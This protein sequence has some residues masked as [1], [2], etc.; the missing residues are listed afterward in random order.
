MSERYDRGMAVL[1]EHFGAKADEYI[2]KIRDISPGFADINVSFPFGDLYSRSELD[3]KTRELLAIAAITC[4]GAPEAQL[5]VHAIG[6]LKCGATTD[7]VYEVIIQMIAYAG[8]PY[9]TNALFAVAAGVSEWEQ[10]Q[11]TDESG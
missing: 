4:L 7:E 10:Q 5:K 11:A 8:F 1:R 2:A 9:A 3:A 6:A